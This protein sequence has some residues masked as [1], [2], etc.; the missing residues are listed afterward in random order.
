[1][2][3]PR[4]YVSN[5]QDRGEKGELW[6]VFGKFGRLTN[7]WV[8]DNPPGFAYVFFENFKDAED[9]V[10]HLDGG[11]V[12]G[13]KVEVKLSPIDEK[14]NQRSNFAPRGRVS[15]GGPH[16]SNS[17]SR[18]G[19]YKPRGDFS[20]PPERSS[21]YDEDVPRNSREGR[22]DY[23]EARS[24][25]YAER[26]PDRGEKSYGRERDDYGPPSQ[27]RAG[28]SYTRGRGAYQS[29][30]GYGRGDYNN[31]ASGG[32]SYSR[33]SDRSSPPPQ[34]PIHRPVPSSRGR[35]SPP[36]PSRGRGGGYRGEG[37]GYGGGHQYARNRPEPNDQ[38]LSRDGSRGRPGGGEYGRKPF[39]PA[40]APEYDR[41]S[42]DSRAYERSRTYALEYERPGHDRN[43][44]AYR[45]HRSR[46]TDK[47]SYRSSAPKTYQRR[48]REVPEK[49]YRKS[50]DYPD[51]RVRD[52]S[53]HRRASYGNSSNREQFEGSSQEGGQY[54][55][56]PAKERK[57]SH[58]PVDN[59]FEG[60]G[61]EDHASPPAAAH[62]EERQ[63]LYNEEHSHER[64]PLEPSAKYAD[65]RFSPA[66][67]DYGDL[68]DE[69]GEESGIPAMED[70]D[71]YSK[72]DDEYGLQETNEAEY[73]DRRV[74]YEGREVRELKY[75]GHHEAERS[76][77]ASGTRSPINSPIRVE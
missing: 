74:E 9:A 19:G 8:A 5:L 35:T 38:Y 63:P 27:S 60:S 42:R 16:P 2:S 43:D 22:P 71:H 15:R 39:A 75:E 57:R 7:V 41:K 14:R 51:V 17:T 29:N 26:Y 3:V 10:R 48:E 50:E 56:R 32:G 36:F 70:V 72:E 59:T 28:A 53:P 4:V 25:A 66:H 21:R 11:K 45:E 30:R 1:M 23:R 61:F 24:N 55:E 62:F 58:T 67:S 77:S 12:C 18:G 46:P 40:P 31:G 44:I 73:K 6:R 65:T 49:E 52:R 34:V 76:Q 69:A 20:S 13:T 37:S 68:P 64:S 54:A 33:Y 47:G